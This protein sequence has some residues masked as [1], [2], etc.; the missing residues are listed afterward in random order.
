MAFQNVSTPR[1]YVSVL[2]YLKSV[3]MISGENL[4]I[5]DINPTNLKTLIFDQDEVNDVSFSTDIPLSS[6][7]PNDKNF[8]MFLGHKFR[9]LDTKAKFVI[10]DATNSTLITPTDLVNSCNAEPSYNGFSI[11]I[12]NNADEI[13]TE[14]EIVF[15]RMDQVTLGSFLYGTYYDMPHSP[16]LNLTLIRDYSGTKTIETKG[17]ATLSNT[18]WNK[19]ASWGG[20][21]AWE[22]YQDELPPTQL[23]RTGRRIWSLNFSMISDS[24][25]WPEYS[26]LYNFT[27]TDSDGDETQQEDIDKTLLSEV[28]FVSQVLQKT[29]GGQL[30]FIF[31]PDNSNSNPDQFSIAKLDMN[32]FSFQQTSYNTYTIKLQIKECW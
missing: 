27:G 31:Q 26:S 6:I 11:Q 20:T 32:S 13:D 3:G 30:P 10:E 21:G 18:M 5:L 17:G 2:Q 12:G 1:F 24:N 7:M 29:N 16:D 25:I 22:L 8:T 23:S 15:D 14:M 28:T 19:P 4:N 9:N